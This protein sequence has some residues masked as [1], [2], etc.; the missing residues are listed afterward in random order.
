MR[1]ELRKYEK[2][3]SE[4][5]NTLGLSEAEDIPQDTSKK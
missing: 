2:H 5:E 4:L 3:Q 1:K